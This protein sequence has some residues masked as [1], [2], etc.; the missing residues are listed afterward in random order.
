MKYFLVIIIVALL[1]TFL[2]AQVGKTCDHSKVIKALEKNQQ[3]HLVQE[4][5]NKSS[6]KDKSDTVITIPVVFHILYKNSTENISDAQVYSQ[7]EVMNKDFRKLN[8]D[9]T[10]VDPPFSYV[11]TKIEFCLAHTDPN[12][13]FSTGITRTATNT[14]DIGSKN[15]Y[16]IEQASWGRD[17]YLNI[18]VCDYGNNIAG[19]AYPPGSPADRDGLVID[20]TNFG[21]IGT[22]AAPYDKGRTVTHEIGHWL[23]LFHIWGQNDASP[24]CSSDD[25]VSDTPDQ[26]KIYFNCPRLDQFSCGSKDMLSNF[27]GYVNDACMAN[28]TQGQKDRMRSALINSRTALLSSDKGCLS[29]GIKENKTVEFSLF[30]N[31]STGQLN[32]NF[33][34][35]DYKQLSII[36]IQGKVYFKGQIENQFFTRNFSSLPE[37][38]YLIQIQ[39]DLGVFSK[40]WVVNKF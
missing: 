17:D 7:L 28:F 11:D 19:R 1:P 36:D 21:T 6:I 9:T 2:F 34:N 4:F 25:L 38:I 3:Y 24:S 15:L 20:Y 29:I 32:I 37:G 35:S 31:P 23:N 33:N 26:S 5:L 39:N 8:S 10:I 18:W 13:N 22:A 30:P 16:F 12:G 14:D 40:K 27:M